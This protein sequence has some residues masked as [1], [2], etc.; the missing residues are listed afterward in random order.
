M[1]PGGGDGREVLSVA[2]M[3]RADQMA[4]AG[5]VPGPELMES[6]GAAVA[7][8]I[9]AGWTPR[10]VAVLCGPGNNGGD[11]FV[12]ARVLESLGW[13]VRLALLGRREA[14]KGDAAQAAA[15][16]RGTVEPLNASVLDGDPLVVDALF[17]AGLARPLD[18]EARALVEACARRRLDVVAVDVPSGVH[19]DTG[20]VLGAAPRAALT[21]TFFRKKPAHLLLPGRAFCGEVVVVDIGIPA[22]V[23]DVLRPAVCENGPSRWLDRFPWPT[24]ESH[25]YSRGHAVVLGGDRMTGA[26][27]LA[28]RAARRAGAGLVTIACPPESVALYAAGEPGA[29]V[30][31]VD[32]DG[33]FTALLQDPRRNAVLIGP[34]AGVSD[35]TRARVMAALD[36]GKATVL[37]ADA[38]TAFAGEHRAGLMSRL[39]GRCVLTPHEG[40]FARLFPGLRDHPKGKVA[41]AGAAAAE[42]GAVVLLKGAD[43]VI[44]A[45]DGRAAINA[46]APAY[47]A[48]AGSGD[49]L[50]GIVVGLM[51]QGMAAFDAACAA[52][53]LHG[54]AAGVAGLGLLAEDLPQALATVLQGLA[55]R[56]S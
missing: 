29:L 43:T 37:D 4:M 56:S 30:H 49:V 40:E 55:S 39:G 2:E 33:A 34:G 44:A 3:V 1:V 51:A 5:G 18:G 50:A 17:G 32:D 41:R 26:A 54:A 19:G 7:Q 52:A 36:A 24:L 45:P 38:L 8:A 27:R 9:V 14:L 16:W 12:A 20:A 25:K 6:A 31:G 47:L 42:T 53:W 28:T 10:P 13:P 15:R 21:V 23:L 48:T 22:T 35:S 46:N 11:G